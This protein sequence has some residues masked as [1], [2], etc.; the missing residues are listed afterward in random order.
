MKGNAD[1]KWS[2][3]QVVAKCFHVIMMSP[4]A[5]CIRRRALPG[6]RCAALVGPVVAPAR[7]RGQPALQRLDA[8][9]DPAPQTHGVQG[10]HLRVREGPDAFYISTRGR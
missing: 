2:C 6:A 8:P 1:C 4:L 5:S 9:P 7:D 3:S 10:E